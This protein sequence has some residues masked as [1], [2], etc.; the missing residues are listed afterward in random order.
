MPE[1]PPHAKA[2]LGQLHRVLVTGGLALGL[3]LPRQSEGLDPTTT[4]IPTLKASESNPGPRPTTY[5]GTGPQPIVGASDKTVTGEKWG[6]SSYVIPLMEVF[7]FE[8]TL[9]MYDRAVLGKG[10]YGSTIN[11]FERN[12]KLMPKIDNDAFQVN[13]LGHPFEGSINFGFARSAGLSY[14]QSM[15]YSVGGS[16]LWETAGETTLPSVNDHI[17]SGVAGAFLGEP[18]FRMSSLV[19]EGGGER[20]GFTREL[21]AA[22]ISPP[23]GANRLL[24]GDRFDDVFPSHNPPTFTRLRLG[25]STTSRESDNGPVETYHRQQETL[26]FLMAYGLPGKAGYTYDRPFDYFN[27]EFAAGTGEGAFE[28]IMIRGLL[29]GKD[30]DVGDSYR[31]I[32]GLYGSYDYISP[33]T[34]RVSSTALSLG[35]T[36]QWWLMPGVALQYSA[37]GGVGYAAAGSIAGVGDRNYRYGTTPQGLLALRLIFGTWAMLD[38]NGR[39]YYISDW[40]GTNPDGHELIGR[41]NAGLTV[42]VYGQNAIGIQFVG[43]T[44]DS[45]T[46]GA[47]DEHQTEA[48]ISLVYTLLGDSNFGAVDW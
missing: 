32:W 7:T 22:C 23:T 17:A 41:L 35:T 24:F 5:E 6:K 29:L 28:N 16:E 36:A 40:G 3:L 31:G 42:R 19:L 39:E 43:T 10:D 48:T 47:T 4:N 2:A 30:Y 38:L 27:F 11:T 8:A 21:F 26:D 44:R 18:L 45:H 15:L 9:N 25:V 46:L 34:F 20:P 12:V 33:E 1:H 14:W 13:Q 37:L